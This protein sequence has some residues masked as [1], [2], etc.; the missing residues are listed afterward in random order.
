MQD[1]REQLRHALHAEQGHLAD[2][3][4]ELQLLRAQLVSRGERYSATLGGLHDAVHAL[5]TEAVTLEDQLV[6]VHRQHAK[7]LA[8]L[9]QMA[10]PAP[11][12][13]PSPSSVGRSL[14]TS[15]SSS[16]I[17]IGSD[18]YTPTGNP[19]QSPLQGYCR[20]LQAA[21]A[22]VIGKVTSS[23]VEHQAA[24]TLAEERLHESHQ[25][26][27][28]REEL[29]GQL[30]LA[31]ESLSVARS[32]L[33]RL[34]S[35]CDEA[36]EETQRVQVAGQEERDKLSGRLDKSE[37]RVTEMIRQVT[38]LQADLRR[39]QSEMA[40]AHS[41]SE[42]RH[43]LL[44]NKAHKLAA[45]R[46]D[47]RG[48]EKA[49]DARLSGLQSQLMAADARSAQQQG[50]YRKLKRIALALKEDLGR[51]TSNSQEQLQALNQAM[52]QYRVQLGHKQGLILA[53]QQQ[54][55]ELTTGNERLHTL[56]AQL[57][58]ERDASP[59][60]SSVSHS[61]SSHSHRSFAPPSAAPVSQSQQLLN[62]SS[63]CS[64]SRQALSGLAQLVHTRPDS[65]A[66]SLRPEYG[67]NRAA[68]PPPPDLSVVRG[69]DIGSGVFTASLRHL[70]A[71]LTDNT[72]TS[73]SNSMGGAVH[74]GGTGTGPG[75]DKGGYVREGDR[76][77]G[78][79]S[80]TPAAYGSGSGYDKLNDENAWSIRAGGGEGGGGMQFHLPPYPQ[81]QQLPPPAMSSDEGDRDSVLD[82]NRQSEGAT[83]TSSSG[84]F[85]LT[86]PSRYGSR[87]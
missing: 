2:K 67:A 32:K 76:E 72:T 54:R 18:R 85:R 1:L 38:T 19:A 7:L 70:T 21:L 12:P 47:A 14:S 56:L 40:A 46:D 52:E 8:L 73:K 71:S 29:R 81:H 84:I 16:G 10:A 23:R 42:T 48:K 11:N 5:T 27:F 35:Q 79:Y 60:H 78:G 59:P 69:T 62:S 64:S 9:Q 22:G 49:A 6:Y 28:E 50:D 44:T 61:H 30:V 57:R 43:G 53:L 20:E 36:V 37:N 33:V 63:S 65:G 45:E 75:A 4:R 26:S 39:V 17:G 3:E 15:Q 68:P 87:E 83:T 58:E 34:Q 74:E 13:P 51:V 41:E 77:A 82:R 66:N 24:L 86:S 55:A 31:E 80:H 25:L